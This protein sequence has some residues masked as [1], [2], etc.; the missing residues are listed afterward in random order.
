[1]KSTIMPA[2]VCNEFNYRIGSSHAVGCVC[3]LC[4]CLMQGVSDVCVTDGR[5]DDS[6]VDPE[7]H[8][9]VLVPPPHTSESPAQVF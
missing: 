5:Y 9:T 4:V 6:I 7:Q 8:I 1:M 2:Q 3:L